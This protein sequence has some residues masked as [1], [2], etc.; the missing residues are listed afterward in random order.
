VTFLRCYNTDARPRDT[1]RQIQF[2]MGLRYK[3]KNNARIP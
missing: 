1:N 2:I 3:F